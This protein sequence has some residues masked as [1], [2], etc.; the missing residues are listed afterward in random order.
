MKKSFPLKGLRIFLLILPLL[1]F[2]FQFNNNFRIIEN[3][4]TKYLANT[5]VVKLKYI[6]S[7]DATGNVSLSSNLSSFLSSFNFKEAR[8]LFPEKIK[9]SSSLARIIEINY[10]SD[11]D[12]LYISSKLKNSFEVEWAEP[13]YVYELD[14]VPN[15][16]SYAS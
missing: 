13:R 9:E 15:D 10:D 14:Y 5:I 2:G 11:V 1:L 3:N 4:G 8:A 12:P 6:P 7:S 16:P